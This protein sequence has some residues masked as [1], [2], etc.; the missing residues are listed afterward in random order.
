MTRRLTYTNLVVTTA[1]LFEIAR[2]FDVSVDALV[3]RLH[4]STGARTVRIPRPGSRRFMRSPSSSKSAPGTFPPPRPERFRALAVTALRSG[5]IRRDVSPST[6][7][8]PAGRR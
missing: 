7:G 5:E 8:L 1:A 4:I 6:S 2:D 3:W